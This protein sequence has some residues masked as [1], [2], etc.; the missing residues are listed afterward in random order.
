MK[1]PNC[2]KH[3]VPEY[4]CDLKQVATDLADMPYDKVSEFFNH[5]TEKL[6]KDADNDHNGGR[7]R[8]SILL[9]STWSQS[10]EMKEMFEKIWKLCEPYMKEN[11]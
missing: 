10:K 2:K 3:I 11:K 9:S 1:K 8:L 7:Y 4:L 5:L 6:G